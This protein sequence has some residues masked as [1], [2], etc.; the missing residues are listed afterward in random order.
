MFR[1]L[2]D[3]VKS[4][5]FKG[6]PCGRSYKRS[7]FHTSRNGHHRNFL[8]P[9]RN[10]FNCLLVLHIPRVPRVLSYIYRLV[11]KIRGRN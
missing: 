9:S 4:V 1:M 6:V 11:E 3:V 10:V 7:E 8:G 2:R 5:G